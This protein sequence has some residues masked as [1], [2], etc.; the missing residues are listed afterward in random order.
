MAE[1]QDGE[2]E[3][4]Q[5][6]ESGDSVARGFAPVLAWVVSLGAFVAVVGLGLGAGWEE[7]I[8]VI[9]GFLAVGAVHLV[10]KAARIEMGS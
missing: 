5:D 9:A 3:G 2:F 1:G 6:I 8:A 4:G 7:W 10:A